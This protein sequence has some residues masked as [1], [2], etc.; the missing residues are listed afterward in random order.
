MTYSEIVSN[1]F[2]EYADLLALFQGTMNNA[3]SGLGFRPQPPE[4]HLRLVLQAW[5][6]I[7]GQ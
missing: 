2:K 3:I 1:N 4:N 6:R 5:R 7:I